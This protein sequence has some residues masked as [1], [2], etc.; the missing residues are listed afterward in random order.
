MFRILIMRSADPNGTETNTVEKVTSED[1]RTP[2]LTAAARIR[3]AAMRL[4]P[5]HGYEGTSIRVLA[6]EVGISP[7]LVIHHFGS[8]EGLRRAC[9]EYVVDR[10]R[11]V[12]GEG[13]TN[14]TMTDSGF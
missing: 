8:K 10:I 7:A 6:E 9:D 5:E 2:D 11:T 14:R 1:T 4:F 12:K 13:I 3:E